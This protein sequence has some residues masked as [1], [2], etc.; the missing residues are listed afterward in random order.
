MTRLCSVA[1]SGYQFAVNLAGWD[2]GCVHAITDTAAFAGIR[3]V[4]PPLL[5]TAERGDV[6]IG[7]RATHRFVAVV[8]DEVCGDDRLTVAQERIGAVPL[9]RRDRRRGGVL[10]VAQVTALGKVAVVSGTISRSG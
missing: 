1:D 8:V 5:L 9:V 7:P 6:E 3:P 10:R 4:S 2:I